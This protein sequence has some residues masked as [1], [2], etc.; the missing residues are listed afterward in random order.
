MQSRAMTKR[1]VDFKITFNTPLEMPGVYNKDAVLELF[2]VFQYSI[3]DA[4]EVSA[5]AWQQNPVETFNTPLEMPSALTKAA[6]ST[7]TCNFQYSI[8][9]A[10][11]SSFETPTRKNNFQYSIRDARE[12][13]GRSVACRRA[14]NTPLEM[15]T[16]PACL[17][18]TYPCWPF[19]TP[20][21]MRPESGPT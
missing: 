16:S 6:T 20:L 19:N 21:E 15:P 13:C 14:F 17:R 10:L 8:R 11:A 2:L 18:S 12:E 5:G 9:D 7:V 4:G 1:R 3:G